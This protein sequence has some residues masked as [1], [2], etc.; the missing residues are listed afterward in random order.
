MNNLN[1]MNNMNLS[2]EPTIL[3]TKLKEI[4]PSIGITIPGAPAPTYPPQSSPVL[5]IQSLEPP[6]QG[7]TGY[8]PSMEAKSW[9]AYTRIQAAQDVASLKMFPIDSIC[10]CE[11]TKNDLA[12]LNAQC[13]KLTEYNCKRI[14]CC[15]F[16]NENKCVAGDRTGPTA[17]YNTNIDYYY[18]K[19]KCY[20][21]NCPKD[22]TC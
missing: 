7:V 2:G 1:N 20:G 15:V 17:E 16:T 5:D 12:A 13:S 14:G 22:K 21:S 6:D 10:E 18:Y 9:A 8:D 3:E 11:E 4:A 19:N